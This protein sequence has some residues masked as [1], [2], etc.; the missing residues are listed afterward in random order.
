MARIW[1]GE[2]MARNGEEGES[3]CKGGLFKGG[4]ASESG[5]ER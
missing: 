4:T 1:C 3:R 2:V 5:N